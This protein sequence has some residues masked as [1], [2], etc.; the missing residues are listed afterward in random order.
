MMEANSVTGPAKNL[1]GFCRWLRTPEGAQTRLEVA[2]ATF[3]RNAGAD[4][5]SFTDAVRAAGVDIYLINERF[6]FDPGVLPQIRDIADKFAPNII[7]THNNKSHLLI[8]WLPEVR[9]RSAWFAFRHGDT[10]TDLK[11]RLFNQVDRV[12]IRSADRVVTVCKA[13]VPR[14]AAC[15]VTPHRMRILHN[16]VV[17]PLPSPPSARSE[18]RSGLGIGTDEA[19]ILTIG[20][21]SREKGHA[22]L[23]RALEQLRSI[24]R[25]WKLVLVGAGPEADTLKRLADSLN[26][27]DRVLFAGSH[28]DVGPFYGAADA[29]VLP[30]LTEGSSNVLLEAMAAKVPIVATQAG[31]NPEIILHGETGLLVPIDDS[32][33]LATAIA[34]LLEEPELASRF[35]EAAFDRVTREFSVD[36]YRRRLVSFYA[37]ALEARNAGAA[38]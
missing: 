15:G 17:P 26:L 32:Q 22:I 34:K 4:N 33:S 25:K 37:E 10:Y 36:K 13:F 8:K 18:L 11:Q 35:A 9:R 7:Q 14:L 28:A 1:L 31:G 29:F 3:T 19:M 12:S 5:Q 21:F 27:R 16:S 24:S 30:S 2:I 38:K 20:R 6:R 23:L